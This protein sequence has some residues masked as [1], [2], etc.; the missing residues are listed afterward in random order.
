VLF[1]SGWAGAS[2]TSLF[3]IGGMDGTSFLED[4]GRLS[5]TTWAWSLI[6][7]WVPGSPHRHGVGVWTG[8]EMVVWSGD[9][10]S[11]NV[12]FGSRWLP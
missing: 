3:A 12:P 1:D 10:G 5:T 4:G 2:G 9:D 6:S 11:T 8:A 7:S